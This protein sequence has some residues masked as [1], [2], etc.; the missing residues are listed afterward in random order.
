MVAGGRDQVIPGIAGHGAKNR[1]LSA[2]AIRIPALLALALSTLS[3]LMA[4]PA[5]ADEPLTQSEKQEFNYAFATQIGSGI[6]TISGRT[7]QVYCLP[8]SY[9]FRSSEDTRAGWRFTFP[10]T[11]GFYN[12]DRQDI[13][14][15][16]ITENVATFSLVPGVEFLMPMR[17]HWLLKPFAEAGYVWDRGG[18]A[19]AA[20]YSAGLRSRVD[21]A[22]KGFEMVLGNGL[23]YARVVPAAL[24]SHDDMVAFETAFTA[25]HLFSSGGQGQADFEPYFVGRV[26]FGG[27]DQPL[28]GGNANTFVQ[29]EVGLTFGSRGPMNIWKIP[30]P[31][32][33][34]GY[35]FGHDISA[36]RIVFGT[37]AP[38]LNP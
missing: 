21:F 27:V 17:T 29:Y 15:S 9:T 6:Y 22:G 30:L 25:N 11:F 13:L 19:D 31:R 16:N 5:F 7:L 3:M 1:L 26:F 24:S 28:S 37:P 23:T 12:F 36:L 4:L 10:M 35:L 8:L 20:T 14:D 38:S 33:G 34:I 32:V 18:D 2:E